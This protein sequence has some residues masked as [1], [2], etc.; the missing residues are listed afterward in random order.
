[1]KIKFSYFI[2]IL[3][4]ASCCPKYPD[5]IK[6]VK[7]LSQDHTAYLTES[8]KEKFILT[9]E[10]QVKVNEEYDK[11]YFSVWH[12]LQPVHSSSEKISLIFKRFALSLGY[13]EK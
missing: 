5:I 2:L 12:N 1:M 10:D 11:I 8:V 4:L 9:K 7:D 6:D 3:F 13:G